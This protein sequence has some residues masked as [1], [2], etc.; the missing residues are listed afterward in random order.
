M[1]RIK[2]Q[3][4]F[5]LLLALALI[6]SACGKAGIF[7]EESRFFEAVVRGN[8]ALNEAYFRQGDFN[9]KYVSSGDSAKPAVIYLHGTPGGWDN[10]ARYLMDSTLQQQAHIISLDRPGWGGSILGG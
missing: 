6:V 9:L 5:T 3:V 10:G 4:Q 2:I 7:V 8:S 1:T